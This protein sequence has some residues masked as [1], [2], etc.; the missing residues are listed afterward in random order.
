[1]PVD[2]GPETDQVFLLLYGTGFR[3]RDV[4]VPVACSVG[5]VATEVT[6]AGVDAS[7]QAAPRRSTDAADRVCGAEA[8]RIRRVRSGGTADADLLRATRLQLRRLAS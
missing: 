5:G 2:L 1:V 4:S 8:A 6:Y 3:K 7:R